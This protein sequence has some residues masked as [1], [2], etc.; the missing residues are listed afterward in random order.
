MT[1]H[2]WHKPSGVCEPAPPRAP[3]GSGPANLCSA[4]RDGRSEWMRDR[5]TFVAKCRVCQERA[6]LDP[7]LR[8]E[9]TPKQ[10]WKIMRE[11][12]RTNAAKFGRMVRAK[13][14]FNA[15]DVRGYAE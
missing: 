7:T 10:L 8:N 1:R 15:S 2:N 13:Q 11:E 3:N 9:P 4:H 14:R 6:A 12:R 5:R